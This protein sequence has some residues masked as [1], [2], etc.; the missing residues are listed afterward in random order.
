MTSECSWRVV[1]D[2]SESYGLDLN[3][4]KRSSLYQGVPDVKNFLGKP[5]VL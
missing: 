4:V 3:Y 5:P 2:H 1:L